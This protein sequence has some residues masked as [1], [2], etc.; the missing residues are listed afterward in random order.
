[1]KKLLPLILSLTFV[2]LAQTPPIPSQP[3]TMEGITPSPIP[4]QQ[5]FSQRDMERAARAI[6]KAMGLAN[7]YEYLRTVNPQAPFDATLLGYASELLARAQNAYGQGAFFSAHEY[8]KAAEKT[9]KAIEASFEAIYNPAVAFGSGR[10]RSSRSARRAMEAPIRAAER[11]Y[12]VEYELSMTPIG[13][14]EASLVQQLLASARSQLE[15][16]STQPAV[17]GAPA[18]PFVHPSQ[19][20]AAEELARAAHHLLRAI[21]G[22]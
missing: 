19:A 18:Y 12:R 3:L 9:Y 16:V 7:Q 2:A 17:P 22:F 21:R 4:P 15:V 6:T 5:F 8:A 1:M 10:G 14:A 11:I 20:K 13:G